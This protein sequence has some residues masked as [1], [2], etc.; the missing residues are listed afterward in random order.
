MFYDLLYTLVQSNL[1]AI[2][3]TLEQTRPNAWN[4]HPSLISHV[5]LNLSF[6]SGFTRIFKFSRPH[7]LSNVLFGQKWV[8]INFEHKMAF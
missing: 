6:D 8:R 3:E 2:Y 7:P 4:M 5:N 1:Y